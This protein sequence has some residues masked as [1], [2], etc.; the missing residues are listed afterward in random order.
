MTRLAFLSLITSVALVCGAGGATAQSGLPDTGSGSSNGSSASTP[1]Y[2][3]D[4]AGRSLILRGFNT[5]SS[6]KS[7]PDGM[8]VFTE[9]DLD[10]EHAAMGTGF[11][12]FLISW[13]SVE[14]TPGQYDQ[15]YLDR[16]EQRVGWYA[17]RGYKVMLDMHQDVYSGA[18]TTAG[19]STSNIGGIGN[20]APAWAT[21]TDGLPVPPQ[22]QWELYY[23][24]PGVIRAFD[25]FWN[26]TGNHPELVEHYANAWRAVAQRF[27]HNDAVVAYDLMN[28]PFG[29]SKQGRAFE[30]GPL[31]AMYQRTT[32]AIRQADHKTWVCVEPQ[33]V[34]VNQGAPSALTKIDDPR[35]GGPRIA[36]CP[37]LYPITMDLG[38]GYT[39]IARV[40]TDASVETWR[41]G[42]QYTAGVLGG[43]PIIIG[44]FGLDT[45]LPGARDYIDHVYDTARKIGAG[46][47]YW[48]SDPG[49]WGPYL[50]N[51]T[52][53]V[54]VDAVNK[55]Y[56][57]AVAGTPVDWSSTTSQLQLTY[58][59][60][61]T[62]G[63][64]TEIYL[65]R[66]GFP[67]DVHVTGAQVVNWD[68]A[69]RLLTV[70]SPAGSG[71]VTLTV[72]PA[73]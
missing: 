13:R 63:A 5:A 66:T 10:R 38:A 36:Y 22:G 54:L 16:V 31:A 68:R 65:P 34:G 23:L 71:T 32:A 55:P 7:T 30:A 41:A 60:D 67:G 45:T 48:S 24:D 14:P 47:S 59:P 72:T 56:P 40:I 21:Y 8:P 44:E 69:S 51:G 39:G 20:G 27:A 2:P 64:P 50:S 43:V 19:V 53:T 3:K 12:R 52:P 57:R 6:A 58:R 9:A 28:E 73:A 61:R 37:H 1:S 33:S 17:A 62:V 29:G 35:P 15:Q 42:V 46:V 26:N 4:D 25:N 70:Q 49:T 11:V 18:I